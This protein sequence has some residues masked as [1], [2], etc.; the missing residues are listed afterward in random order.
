M[1][2][3]TITAPALI[4]GRS[5]IP[6]GLFARLAER[7]AAEHPELAPGMPDRILDQALA[8]LGTCSVATEPVGPSEAVD[9][10]W[11]T[12]ILYTTEYAEFC[13]RVAGRFI[14]HVPNDDCAVS[15]AQVRLGD[16]VEAITAAGYR[17]DEEL[18]PVNTRV[19]C[20]QCYQGCSDTPNG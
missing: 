20:S 19:D 3:S 6:A 14:H 2:T 16:V 8:F 4:D 11:H 17:V 18:W 10:G 7:I 5:L 1:S 15:P 13:N 9:I 12:F